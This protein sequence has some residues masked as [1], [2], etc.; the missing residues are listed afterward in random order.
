MKFEFADYIIPSAIMASIGIAAFFLSLFALR[1]LFHRFMPEDEYK[2]FK[3][4]RAN[5][6][7]PL[8]IALI[9][10]YIQVTI[11]FKFAVDG[12]QPL[13]QSI[14]SWFSQ[15]GVAILLIALAAYISSKVLGLIIPPAIHN[16]T[17][18]R[19]KD[20]SS[21]E[22]IH[23]RASMLSN[24]LIHVGQAIIIIIVVFM[25]LSEFGIDITP[26]LAGAGVVGLAV[27]LGAQKFIGDLVNGICIIVD[28]YYSVGDVVTIAGISGLVEEVN[29]RRTILRDMNGVVHII[30]NSEIKIASNLTKNWSRVNINIPVSYSEDLDRVIDVLNKVGLQLSLDE[31]FKDMIITAPQVLRVDNFA[32]SAIEIKML[33]DT[34]PIKQWEVTGELRKRIKKAF[35][36][37]N[38]EI[39]WPH[40]KVYSGDKNK[41]NLIKSD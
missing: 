16:V 5:I 25:I 34:K 6:I 17:N 9:I 26:M 18:F 36:E 35:D 10:I 22:E 21:Q 15:H 30:P 11:F 32:D 40:I 39:P 27:G 38:I 12:T 31:K 1:K 20:T 14:T 19:N 37:E 2:K 3:R 7:I 23:K 24:F 29:I 41:T 4:G 33:G 13:W 28:D 8:L